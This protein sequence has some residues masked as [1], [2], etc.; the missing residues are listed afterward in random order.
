MT[1][2][3]KIPELDRSML[4]LDIQQERVR[5]DC[6]DTVFNNTNAIILEEKVETRNAMTPT[7]HTREPTINLGDPK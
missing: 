4:G 3:S 6:I 7:E 5:S 2:G 1:Y